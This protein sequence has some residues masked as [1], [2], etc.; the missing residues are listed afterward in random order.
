VLVNNA[1]EGFSEFD[2]HFSDEFYA[3]IDEFIAV[4]DSS[5]GKSKLYERYMSGNIYKARIIKSR[6]LNERI[7]KENA[8]LDSSSLSKDDYD[9]A[10]K[11]NIEKLTRQIN[12]ELPVRKMEYE[13]CYF[14]DDSITFLVKSVLAG[15]TT[16]EAYSL[17]LGDESE[18]QEME[19][20]IKKANYDIDAQEFIDRAKERLHIQ[21]EDILNM[22]ITQIHSCKSYSLDSTFSKETIAV[23]TSGLLGNEYVKFYCQSSIKVLLSRLARSTKYVFAAAKLSKL[24]STLAVKEAEKRDKKLR[25]FESV[26][27][28]VRDDSR[29]MLCWKKIATKLIREDPTL[30]P[31]Y[32]KES[33]VGVTQCNGNEIKNTTIRKFILDLKNKM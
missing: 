7:D 22:I 28:L 31:R 15:K 3:E 33:L 19:N 14:S 11:E 2:D 29:D 1:D 20:I 27:T 18:R 4:H 9:K 21:S 23:L 25:T 6:A 10:V 12:K 30:E 5:D 24:E 13:K 32:I 16:T 26:I 8:K 17:L